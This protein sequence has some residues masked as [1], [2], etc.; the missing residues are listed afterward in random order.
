MGMRVKNY[1][2]SEPKI[3]YYP[4]E[5]TRMLVMQALIE[6]GCPS[7]ITELSGISFSYRGEKFRLC[8]LTERIISIGRC[9]ASFHSFE[10]GEELEYSKDIINHTN[11]VGVLSVIYS[12]HN[13]IVLLGV[14]CIAESDFIREIRYY[15]SYI[16]NYCFEECQYRIEF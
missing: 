6:I 16:L 14:W 10:K 12:I 7:D 5:R 4:F 15:I 8:I 9:N 3:R 11:P 13:D 2:F 1:L